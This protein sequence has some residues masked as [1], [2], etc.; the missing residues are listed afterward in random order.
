MTAIPLIYIT[1][2]GTARA[3]LQSYADVF[4]GELSLHSFADFGRT[5]G[6][7]DAVAHGVLDGPVSLAGSDAGEGDRAVQVEGLMLSLLG[8]AQPEVLHRWFD[9]LAVDGRVL[10]PLEAKPWGAFDG[11]VV[12]RNG[13]RWLVGYEPAG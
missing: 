3:A 6:P 4:G 11:Q 10:D 5:D 13:L 2:P 12:D 1:F 7:A 9:G 8:A